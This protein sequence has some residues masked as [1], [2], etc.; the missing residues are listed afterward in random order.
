MAAPHLAAALDLDQLGVQVVDDAART[1]QVIGLPCEAPAP[2]AVHVDAPVVAPALGGGG[3]DHVGGGALEDLGQE[4]VQGLAHA[5][6]HVELLDPLAQVAGPAQAGGAGDHGRVLLDG[7]QQVVGQGTQVDERVGGLIHVL[8]RDP[9]PGAGGDL[10]GE[11]SQG[12]PATQEGQGLL[13]TVLVEAPQVLGVDAGPGGRPVAT[14]GELGELLQRLV[15]GDRPGLAGPV[16]GAHVAV[17]AGAHRGEAVPHGDDPGDVELGRLDAQALA[18]ALGGVL[19]PGGVLGE[20]QD[21]GAQALLAQGGRDGVPVGAGGGHVQ[22][23]APG[24]GGVGEDGGQG[25]GDVGAG[26]RVDEEARPGAH[27]LDD[28][29]LGGLQVAHAALGA[30]DPVGGDGGGKLHAEGL[31]GPLVPGDGGNQGGGARALQDGVEVLHQGLAGVD[32]GADDEAL[33]NLEAG[34]ELPAQGTDAGQGRTRREARR[35]QGGAG[36]VPDVGGALVAAQGAGE[37]RVDLDGGVQGEGGVRGGGGQAHGAQ[38]DRG[39]DR[40]H[41]RG[42]GGLGDGQSGGGQGVAGGVLGGDALDVRDLGG[43]VRLR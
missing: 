20:V 43:Q 4:D 26:G 11:Q 33:V 6:E 32:E 37:D 5:V 10:R 1:H 27:R 39:V 41:A 13:P 23:G 12:V 7:G 21:H 8:H 28:V 36:D 34:Q 31:A 9:V 29:E 17:Q 2:R 25:A 14:A 35:G 16:Q 38:Q 24:G 40:A 19:A 22:D 3:D 18:D 15:G 30:G 42:R